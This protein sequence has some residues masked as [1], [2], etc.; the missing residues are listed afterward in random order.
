V[1]I[2][3]LEVVIIVKKVDFE[4]ELAFVSLVLLTG[5]MDVWVVKEVTTVVLE[6]DTGEV[7]GK[8]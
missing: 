8:P 4:V 7:V 1:G 3:V 5:P 2:K 6:L